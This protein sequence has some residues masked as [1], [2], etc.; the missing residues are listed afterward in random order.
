[1]SSG[2]ATGNVYPPRMSD[3]G[4]HESTYAWMEKPPLAWFGV[5]ATVLA[6]PGA[7]REQV[8]TAYGL[9]LA[10]DPERAPFTGDD[11]QVS[12]LDS[13]DGS[14]LALEHNGFTASRP[15]LIEQLSAITRNRVA[16]AFWNVNALVTFG[17]AEGGSLQYRGEFQFD[18][19]GL[20]DGLMW[21]L[22]RA[23]ERA[24]VFVPGSSPYRLA[25]ME[26][27]ETYTGLVLTA[28]MVLA[29]AAP[30]SYLLRR[31]PPLQLGN[32]QATSRPRHDGAGPRPQGWT[33]MHG[34]PADWLRDS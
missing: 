32:G 19:D 10:A 22:D 3:G 12:I 9:D 18:R 30:P 21:I 34:A 2:A 17:C 5:A 26:M 31:N 11:D 23:D 33:P 16:F 24:E 1:M 7:T 15:G 29:A 4:V 14:T 25:A 6:A 8:A 27:L 13:G 20:P 28:E